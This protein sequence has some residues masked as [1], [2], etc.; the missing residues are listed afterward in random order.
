MITGAR[1]ETTD[2]GSKSAQFP[3]VR[4]ADIYVAAIRQHRLVSFFV[5]VVI[6]GVFLECVWTG[7]WIR[8]ALFVTASACAVL[9]TDFAVRR[10][11]A[12]QDPIPVRRPVLELTFVL[13]C[14]LITA[15]VLMNYFHLQN[16]QEHGSHEASQIAWTIA[17]FFFRSSLPLLLFSVLVMKYRFAEVGFRL[18]GLTSAIYIIGCFAVIASVFRSWAW[19]EDHISLRQFYVGAMREEGITSVVVLVWLLLF[20][21]FSE[22]FLRLILQSRLNGVLDNAAAAWFI[23]AVLWSLLHLPRFG[24]L[25]SCFEIMLEGLLWGYVMYR[26]RSLLPSM[27]LHATNFV[28]GFK[29]LK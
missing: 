29:I 18:A 24:S 7:A 9:L 22:E 10:E 28:W 11:R 17:L 26:T 16:G 15:A 14:Y 5:L 19:Q 21:A 27:L 8:T 4:T 6:T 12:S 13:A 20:I 2:S 1:T 25:R 23:T 3:L